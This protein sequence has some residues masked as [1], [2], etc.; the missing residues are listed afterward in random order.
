[1]SKNLNNKTYWNEYV[2]Y[3]E[4]RVN[5]TNK[6]VEKKDITSS[7]DILVKNLAMLELSEDDAF[8]DYGCGTCRLYEEYKRLFPNS[9][10]YYGV[11]ISEIA[12][13]K[14][15]KKF[16]DIPDGH[17]LTTDGIRNP[18]DDNTFDKIFC[19]GVLDC[20]DQ[21]II[22]SELIRVAK[23]EGLIWITGKNFYYYEDDD[24]AYEAEIK[25]RN[26]NFPN[27]FTKV[28]KLLKQLLEGGVEIVKTLYF[29]RRGNA[30]R[31]EYSLDPQEKFYEWAMLIRKKM[32]K[33]VTLSN[34]AF[35]YSYA[36]D[37]ET[38]RNMNE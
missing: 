8:L 31:F 32:D 20:C 33:E 13:E 35:E 34:I 15:K 4:N 17:L 5:D 24:L 1:M 11:D 16:E 3:W 9:K 2:T 6:G 30:A 36:F 7:D 27:H 14:A 23:V 28:E 38:M 21:E 25:A 29:P 37:D 22:I 19:Y 26:N 10:N 12:L 18:F